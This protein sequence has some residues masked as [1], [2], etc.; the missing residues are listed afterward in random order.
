MGMRLEATGIG[1]RLEAAG[2]GM[3]LGATGIGM[4][5]EA[6]GTGMRLEACIQ[7]MIEP[8]TRYVVYMHYSVFPE[9]YQ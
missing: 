3:R 7:E 1:T 9:Y 8:Y 4:R 2:I 5:L 6:A